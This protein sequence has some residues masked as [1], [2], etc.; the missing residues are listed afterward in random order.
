MAFHLQKGLYLTE[1]EV[2]TISERDQ[3]VKGT[4]Q[5]E[6][7]AQDFPFVE[8]FTDARCDLGEQVQTVN[9]L[10]DVGLA[11]GDED[12]VQLVQGLVNEADIVLLNGSMLGSRVCEFRK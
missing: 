2:F 11:I 12:D 8:T 1:G 9:V 10:Q 3:F 7:I 4:E 6:C 5:L